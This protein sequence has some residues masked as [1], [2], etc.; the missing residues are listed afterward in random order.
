M[1]KLDPVTLRLAGKRDTAQPAVAVMYHSVAAGRR[2]PNWPWAV[3][4]ARFRE[5]LDVLVDLGY[6]TGTIGDLVRAPL[7]GRLVALT[8]DDGYADN[9]AVAEELARRGMCASW[10]VVTGSLGGKPAW[11]D[12]GRPP[13][14]LMDAAELRS[15]RQAG[16]EV[17]SH[18]VSHLR[19]PSASPADVARELRDS[20]A[21][22]ED[23]LGEAVTSFAYP[24]G[25]WDADCEAAVQKAGYRAACTTQT[26]WAL[27]DRDPL[28]IRRL[29]IFNGDSA[30][31]FVRKLA[32]GSHDVGW[33]DM[34]RYLARR[35]AGRLA[36]GD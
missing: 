3:S 4:L 30:G 31:R 14:R 12:P 1:A 2:T 35:M 15:L 9:L 25:L 33:A 7:R 6:S 32:L 28:R 8:F 10:F 23:W 34:A 17:G 16:M 21:A 11:E 26:G 27:Y 5:H 36:K 20:R 29:T 18:T 22:L 13:G 24:Y 19:M